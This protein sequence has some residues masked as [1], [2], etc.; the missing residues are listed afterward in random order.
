[1]YLLW[2]QQKMCFSSQIK[3]VI[4]GNT[5]I[6]LILIVPNKSG[7]IMFPEII[8]W[9]NSHFIVIKILHIS[10]LHK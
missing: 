1:M 3:S 6:K 10:L 9:S 8:L 4:V 5:P 2:K 7:I